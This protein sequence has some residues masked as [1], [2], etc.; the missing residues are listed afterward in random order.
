MDEPTKDWRACTECG[1]E[2]W[3]ADT[4]EYDTTTD[5]P[6]CGFATIASALIESPHDYLAADL[7]HPL[8]IFSPD[9]KEN[10]NGKD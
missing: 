9:V 3:E 2:G 4:E 7:V 1:W 8:T 5:C 6:A 10:D